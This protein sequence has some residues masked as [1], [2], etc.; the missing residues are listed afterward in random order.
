MKA[1]YRIF[2]AHPFLNALALFALLTAALMIGWG[3]V[4][5]FKFPL[6]YL[7]ADHIIFLPALVLVLL[8]TIWL[9]S[10]SILPIIKI[11]SAGITA[12]SIFWKKTIDWKCPYV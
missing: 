3:T 1:T 8:F 4:M 9:L 6:Q 10:S 12:W 11:T 2:S 5:L 7:T